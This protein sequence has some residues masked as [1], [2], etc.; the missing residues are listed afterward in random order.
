MRRRSLAVLAVVA[1][2]VSAGC[3]GIFGGGV[4]E[5]ELEATPP[6][7][8]D[9]NTTR[10]VTITIRDGTHQAVYDLENTTELN[11]FTR[12]FGSNEPLSFRSL[13]Y[14]YPNG[15]VIN[16]SAPEISVTQQGS[17]RVVEVPNGSGMV[18][19]TSGSGGKT[20]GTPGYLEGSYEVI[21]PPDRRVGS[22]LFGEV[23]PGGWNGRID[24][25]GRLH[26]TWD[27]VSGSVFVRYYLARDVLIFRGLVLVA[28]LVGGGG[29]A[30]YYREIRKLEEQREELG[31]DVDTDD[32]LGDGG[33]PPGMR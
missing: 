31:L 24:D 23:S 6:E 16:G 3:T 17:K 1:L 25:R 28:L 26:I 5:G 11:L 21:L 18:A 15:T 27:D 10:T 12:G 32:D 22:F 20:F 13:R 2:S 8:Y 4:S 9:W 19:Y 7:P 29:M 33:P 14:R 30:Y